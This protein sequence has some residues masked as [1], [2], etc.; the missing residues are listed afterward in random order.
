MSPLQSAD[1]VV[2]VALQ[3]C[4]P[5]PVMCPVMIGVFPRA[6]DSESA[7]G[8]FKAVNGLCRLFAQY[9]RPPICKFVSLQIGATKIL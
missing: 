5:L 2:S 3:F 8:G 1:Y 4:E 7:C 9:R 6:I